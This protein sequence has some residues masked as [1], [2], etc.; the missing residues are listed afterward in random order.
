MLI[1]W[2]GRGVSTV[3]PCLASIQ[4]I[5]SHGPQAATTTTANRVDHLQACRQT[6][7]D[8][9]GRAATEAEAIEKAA[10]EFKQHAAKLMAGRRCAAITSDFHSGRLS[11][12]VGHETTSSTAAIAAP[13]PDQYVARRDS[14]AQHE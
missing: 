1:G 9:R 14:V 3:A 8:W 5:A 11:V 12:L 6:N 10:A 4:Y 2:C 13:I 7:T